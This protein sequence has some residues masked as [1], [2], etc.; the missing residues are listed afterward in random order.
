M[1]HISKAASS[2][3]INMPSDDEKDADGDTIMKLTDWVSDSD[4]QPGEPFC[5][6][7]YSSDASGL[8]TFYNWLQR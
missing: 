8:V 3:D 2:D 5:L 7:A 4:P 6:D 1:R